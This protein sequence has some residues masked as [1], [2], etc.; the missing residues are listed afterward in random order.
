MMFEECSGGQICYLDEDVDDED[1]PNSKYTYT[2]DDSSTSSVAELLS[3]ADTART[4]PSFQTSQIRP[5]A[6]VPLA[7]LAVYLKSC[8]ELPVDKP[9]SQVAREDSKMPVPISKRV[10]VFVICL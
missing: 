7:V 3:T 2:D 9:P 8:R 5:G 6:R 1:S 10:S 4:S